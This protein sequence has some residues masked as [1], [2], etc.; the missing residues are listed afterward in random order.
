MLL[1][2]KSNHFANNIIQQ[3][4][5]IHTCDTFSNL[6]YDFPIT[7]ITCPVESIS[8]V[9]KFDFLLSTTYSLLNSLSCGSKN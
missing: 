4:F 3:I 7:H 1:A 2:K 6:K 9:W 8:A 5:R